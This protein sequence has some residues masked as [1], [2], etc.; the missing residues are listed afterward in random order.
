MFCCIQISN[1]VAYSCFCT[2]AHLI[3]EEDFSKVKF[4]FRRVRTS[5]C[6]VDLIRN[7]FQERMIK[8]SGYNRI[9]RK[10]KLVE[11][12]DLR[13][14]VVLVEM[15]IEKKYEHGKPYKLKVISPTGRFNS[16]IPT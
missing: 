10:L 2:I 8:I 4:D 13:L 14:L 3:R 7:V 12:T 15:I 6:R 11:N 16:S 9:F 5:K 1:D